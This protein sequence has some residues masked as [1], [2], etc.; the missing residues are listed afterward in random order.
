MGYIVG[1]DGSIVKDLMVT[2]GKKVQDLSYFIIFFLIDLTY[3]KV[4]ILGAIQLFLGAR[5]FPRW[6]NWE[7]TAD[8]VTIVHLPL[9]GTEY[10]ERLEALL[11]HL[12]ELLLALLVELQIIA[13]HVLVPISAASEGLFH[14]FPCCFR[15]IA[16]LVRFLGATQILGRTWRNIV[17]HTWAPRFFF[18]SA[19]F[20]QVGTKSHCILLTFCVALLQHLVL[21]LLAAE[22]HLAPLLW[23]CFWV[24]SWSH[25]RSI[26]VCLALVNSK[27]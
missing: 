9:L 22:G 13:I 25:F 20:S 8:E 18:L 15:H 16:V 2:I 23:H 5:Q 17:S 6:S 7:I 4:P 10:L 27:L 19:P 11:F 1:S 26:W 12:L 21:L 24:K 14:E 3:L